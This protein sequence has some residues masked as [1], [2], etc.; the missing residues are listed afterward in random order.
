MAKHSDKSD[1]SSDDSDR[2]EESQRKGI[3][4]PSFSD[5]FVTGAWHDPKR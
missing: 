1:T 4:T 5:V 2:R 3:V